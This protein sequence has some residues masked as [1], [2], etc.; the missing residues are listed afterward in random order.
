MASSS[1]AADVE[2]QDP[3][4]TNALESEAPRDHFLKCKSPACCLAARL[5]KQGLGAQ[6]VRNLS[7]VSGVNKVISVGGLH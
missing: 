2:S 6:S 1:S 7:L 4:S 3:D 5:Q